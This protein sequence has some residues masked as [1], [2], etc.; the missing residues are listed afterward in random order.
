MCSAIVATVGL[1][2]SI[3]IGVFRSLI[4]ELS[5]LLVVIGPV[6]RSSDIYVRAGMIMV[7]DSKR[8]WNDGNSHFKERNHGYFR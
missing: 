2:R 3:V 6:T 7:A 8:V 5:Y 4:S 1:K